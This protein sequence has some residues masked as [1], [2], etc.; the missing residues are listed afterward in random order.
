MENKTYISIIAMV[1]IVAIFAMFLKFNQPIVIDD[2]S[3]D[4]ESDLYL[5]ENISCEEDF[6]ETYNDD[7]SYDSETEIVGEELSCGE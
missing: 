1:A 2:S 4:Y 6:G 5:D 3:C 7:S